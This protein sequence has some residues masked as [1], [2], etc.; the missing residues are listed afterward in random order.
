[1]RGKGTIILF[2]FSLIDLEVLNDSE[3]G[4]YVD[5]L[6]AIVMRIWQVFNDTAED[7]RRGDV[8]W[9]VSL[10]M[11]VVQNCHKGA[12]INCY[13]DWACYMYIVSFACRS[14]LFVIKIDMEKCLCKPIFL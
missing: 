7:I 13:C 2:P 14:F 11:G 5:G 8:D 12:L 3:R 1:M 10:A 9:M 4:V 6:V